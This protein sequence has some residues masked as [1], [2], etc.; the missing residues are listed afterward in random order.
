VFLPV[1]LP[2]WLY[3]PSTNLKFDLKKNMQVV[4]Y[5]NNPAFYLSFYLIL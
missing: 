1:S 4:K 5:V 2:P 3:T